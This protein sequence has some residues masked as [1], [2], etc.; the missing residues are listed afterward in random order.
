MPVPMSQVRVR[1][2][3]RID[4]RNPDEVIYELQAVVTSATL[5]CERFVV[6]YESVDKE[7][8]ESWE[9][10]YPR[11]CHLYPNPELLLRDI[12]YQNTR[13]AVSNGL[14]REVMGKKSF[15]AFSKPIYESEGNYRAL[16]KM[17]EFQDECERENPD[18]KSLTSSAVF[19]RDYQNSVSGSPPAVS[20]DGS[21]GEAEHEVGSEADSEA[22]A[23]GEAGDA[24]AGSEAGGEDGC[25]EGREEGREAR[26]EACSET[27]NNTAADD[28]YGDGEYGLGEPECDSQYSDQMPSEEEED[29][30]D[31]SAEYIATSHSPAHGTQMPSLP[32]SEHRAMLEDTDKVIDLLGDSPTQKP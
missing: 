6:P 4:T 31:L 3:K 14:L 22:E 5:P 8:R 24:A 26:S 30:E 18:F 10:Y 12:A 17:Q 7:I 19:D 32:G 28:F 11:H 16:L 27:P 13:T 20:E 23:G 1:S 2:G 9:R 21:E 15:K 25:E 29:E